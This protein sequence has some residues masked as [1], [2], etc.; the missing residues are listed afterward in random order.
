MARKF[1]EISIQLWAQVRIKDME[2]KEIET[3]QI[4]SEKLI[5]QVQT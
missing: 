2:L 1:Q 3:Q 4:D 5:E